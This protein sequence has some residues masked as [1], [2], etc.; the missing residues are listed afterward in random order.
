MRGS[1]PLGQ[2]LV[3]RNAHFAGSRAREGAFRIVIIA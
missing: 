1:T 3:R 2:A